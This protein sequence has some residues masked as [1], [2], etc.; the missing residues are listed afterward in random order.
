MYELFHPLVWL[1][2]PTR[3][4]DCGGMDARQ[5]LCSKGLWWPGCP[6]SRWHWHTWCVTCGRH[7]LAHVRCGDFMADLGRYT[8]HLA[9]GLGGVLTL[10][11][12]CVTDNGAVTAALVQDLEN[13]RQRVERL[14]AL[15]RGTSPVPE[16]TQR[17]SYHRE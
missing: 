10:L 4:R 12:G 15:A 17:A 1:N 9:R 7:W 8:H 13:A 11:E 2:I 16:V 14:L 3:C 6:V 5:H